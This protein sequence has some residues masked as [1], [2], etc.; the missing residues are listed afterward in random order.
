MGRGEV[1]KS[2]GQVS[3]YSVHVPGGGTLV[4]C[5]KKKYNRYPD[6]CLELAWNA[7]KIY[8][9]KGHVFRYHIYHVCES[10]MSPLVYWYNK[11]FN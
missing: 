6:T 1:A 2:L 3:T 7:I 11:H 4:A 8:S 10:E 9:W 5:V